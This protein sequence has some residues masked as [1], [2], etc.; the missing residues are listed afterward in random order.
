MELR[1]KHEDNNNS[2]E[3]KMDSWPLCL[4]K[5][6]DPDVRFA[7]LGEAEKRGLTPELTP[8]IRTMLEKRYKQGEKPAD[9]YLRFWLTCSLA[10]NSIHDGEI[11]DRDMEDIRKMAEDLGFADVIAEHRDLL[12]QEFYQTAILYINLSLTDKRYGSVVFGLGKLS[13]EKLIRKI[14]E[15][16]YRTG[17][18]VPEI[19]RFAGYEVWEEALKAACTDFFPQGAE[20]WDEVHA[21]ETPEV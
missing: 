3:Q 4:Y 5:E 9:T 1:F 7:M 13:D 10:G 15:D 19:V 21:S 17:Y 2:V 16:T 20:V 18:I 14:C 11:P 6:R 8:V 12:Y